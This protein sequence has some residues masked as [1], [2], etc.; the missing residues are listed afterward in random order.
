MTVNVQS[1]RNALFSKYLFS[2]ENHSIAPNSV[3]VKCFEP[4]IHWW[5]LVI[6]LKLLSLFTSWIQLIHV[7]C[8]YCSRGMNKC[9][10]LISEGDPSW[11]ITSDSHL[12]V[13]E[14]PLLLRGFITHCRVHV[15]RPLDSLLSQFSAVYTLFFVFFGI[16]FSPALVFR[17]FSSVYF[18][19]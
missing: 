12:G 17:M 2:I 15:C 11:G 4:W 19:Q 7:G 13:N 6:C 8:S 16:I 3:Q 9:P 5:I 14:I 1:T 10:L 18:P